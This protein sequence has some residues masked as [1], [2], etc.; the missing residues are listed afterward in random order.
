[1]V[2][3]KKN[4]DVGGHHGQQEGQPHRP[5]YVWHVYVTKGNVSSKFFSTLRVASVCISLGEASLTKPTS[6]QISEGPNICFLLT[7][8]VNPS[9]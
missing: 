7:S 1:M 4:I 6:S 2:N 9:L 3:L 8:A 5:H